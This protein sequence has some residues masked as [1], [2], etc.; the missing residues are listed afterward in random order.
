MARRF[1]QALGEPVAQV[2]SPLL[3][4]GGVKPS[5]GLLVP[6]VLQSIDDAH[7]P[8]LHPL[9]PFALLHRQCRVP[10]RYT[11]LKASTNIPG[12]QSKE[13]LEAEVELFG[14]VQNKKT[15][16]NLFHK[17]VDVGIPFEFGVY[18]DSQQFGFRYNW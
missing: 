15:F 13:C 14:S 5:Q 8:A 3:Q 1:E 17:V 12:V 2:Y 4:R 7:A 16:S 9:K 10:H 18:V 6:R 11:V